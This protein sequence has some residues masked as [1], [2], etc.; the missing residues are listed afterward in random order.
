[1]RLSQIPAVLIA[2]AVLIGESRA[3]TQYYGRLI[4]SF[5]TPAGP[6]GVAG[7]V[8]AVDADRVQIVGFS[9]DGS[10]QDVQFR[11]GT[12]DSPDVGAGVVVPDEQ[13][14]ATP[15]GAYNNRR[16]V[17]TFPNGTTLD[18]TGNIGH[19]TVPDGFVY[20][21]PRNVGEFSRRQHGVRSGEVTITDAKTFNIQNLHYDGF[22]PDAFF[23]AGN[24]DDRPSPRGFKVPDESGSFDQR[25]KRYTGQ[26]IDI[27][28]PGDVTVYDIKWL[29]MW[30]IRFTAN[31]GEVFIPSPADLNVPPFVRDIVAPP[32]ELGNCE[33]LHDDLQV[34]WELNGGNLELQLAGR[35]AD[36]D[37]MAFG[38]SGCADR[39]CMVGSDVT[40]TWYDVDTPRAVDYTLGAYSQCSGRS[41]VCPDNRVGGTEDNFD[42]TGTRIDGVTRIKY[43]RPINTGDTADK[44]IDPAQ[45][46][47]ISWA[48]GPINPSGLAAKHHTRADGQSFGN[49]VLRCPKI[50]IFPRPGSE[51]GNVQLQFGRSLSYACGMIGGGTPAPVTPWPANTIPDNVT[52][53][54]ARIGP[55]G[56]VRGYEGITGQPGWGIAWYINGLLI[57]ELHV[58]RR[59]NYTFIV[60]GG[61]DAS[62]PAR[63]H[64]F[65]ITDDPKGGYI[66]KTAA[67]KQE[68]AVFAGVDEEGN[69]T[70]AGRYCEYTAPGGDTPE[71]SETFAEYFR[72]LNLTCEPGLPARLYWTPDDNTPDLVYYQKRRKRCRPRNSWRRNK[73]EEMRRVAS[74]WVD[75]RKTAQ[76][77]AVEICRRSPSV[78]YAPTGAKGLLSECFTHQYLGWKINVVDADVNAADPCSPNPCQR[79]G[80]CVVT[81]PTTFICTCNHR[82]GGD[83]CQYACEDYFSGSEASRYAVYNNRCYWFSPAQYRSRRNYR[84][85][86]AD[87]VSRSSGRGATLA[88]IKDADTQGFV[89]RYLRTVRAQG[90]SLGRNQAVQGVLM[91][92]HGLKKRHGSDLSPLLQ[93]RQCRY[94]TSAAADYWIGLD[95]RQ[96][97]G[98]YVWNDGTV[99]G[100]RN[101]ARTP[102]RRRGKDCAGVMASGKWDVY[103]CRQ[104]K[105]YICQMPQ[106]CKYRADTTFALRIRGLKMGTRL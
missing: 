90:L 26:T 84:K 53:F 98:R 68:V 5:P 33:E 48:M 21:R 71:A 56:G 55:A 28:L 30:C 65:Y 10:V 74:R 100:Y 13:G 29:S 1:M 22:G 35:V 72:R 69:P 32:Q 86:R 93:G 64:P 104:R 17:L 54:T 94:G 75:L 14:R 15:L 91:T 36:G 66:Q 52:T 27:V 67:E 34:S 83:V 73:E 6:G 18:S 42:V 41:G 92:Q 77:S 61:D 45:N 9:F 59:Q 50:C 78:A 97:E 62:L 99:L 96:I 46:M 38:I 39:T 43:S 70:A 58:K 7:T 51:T 89:E 44:V 20:P 3:Q 11:A 24:R 103:R 81:G 105:A 57:P 25:L 19:V 49:G 37:Y 85:A 106:V 79:Q 2:V 80:V 47:F 88:L 31:F 87:C 12:T 76:R 8:Y 40:V 101:W 95:D 82:Y 23:W 63:Y 4:G 16:I 60:E 102:R